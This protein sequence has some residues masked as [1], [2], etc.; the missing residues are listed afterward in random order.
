MTNKTE[1]PIGRMMIKGARL[2]FP[3]VFTPQSTNGGK[4]R[5]TCTLIL[6]GEH[7]QLAAVD[8][9]IK[10][11]AKAK[12][13]ERAGKIYEGLKAKDNLCL[14]D[15]DT[16]AEYEGFEGNVF[17]SCAAPEG[18]RP[19]VIDADK[20]PLTEKDGKI[21]AGCYVNASIEIWAQDDANGKRINARLRGIQFY[22][23]G[24]AFGG[25][26]PADADEFDDVSDGADDDAPWGDDEDSLA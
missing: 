12:W 4:P 11:V 7:P 2:A 5:Y 22:R 14:H 16:K 19:T 17:I 9:T 8:K 20:T 18:G 1:A 15:G 10:A 13:G 26:R 24:D 6:E 3:N 25:G 21:Y 23:D